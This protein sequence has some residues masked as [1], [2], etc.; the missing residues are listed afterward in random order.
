MIPTRGILYSDRKE[1][2]HF[3]TDLFFSFKK[4]LNFGQNGRRAPLLPLQIRHCNDMHMVTSVALL[5]KNKRNGS[6]QAHWALW[7]YVQH[8]A[9]LPSF[10]RY[11]NARMCVFGI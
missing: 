1:G 4:K 11:K 3:Q 5:F 6:A 7:I 2:T 10:L 8:H 9:L